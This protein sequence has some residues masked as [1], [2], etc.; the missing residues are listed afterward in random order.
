MEPTTLNT[1]SEGGNGGMGGRGGSRANVDSHGGGGGGGGAGGYGVVIVGSNLTLTNES[2]ISGG[3]GGAGG[4]GCAG[5]PGGQG[6]NGGDGG[7]GVFLTNSNTLIN[8]GTIAGGNGG[9]GGAAGAG[10]NSTPGMIGMAGAGGVGVVG[11]GNDTV[12]NSGTISGGFRGGIDNEANRADAV[13]LFG[14][15]NTLELRAGF[16]IVGNAVSKGPSI[17]SPSGEHFEPGGDTLALGGTEESSFNV[18]LIGNIG[19]VKA[20]YQGFG[21]LLKPAPAPGS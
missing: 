10:A 13:E 16:K 11:T 9:A 19:E 17:P 21:S 3:I 14:G 1:G 6:G 8:A 18:A 4:A 5:G 2:D 7:V 15:G 20:Q 12:I